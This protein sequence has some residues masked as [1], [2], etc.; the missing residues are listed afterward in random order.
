MRVDELI[1]VTILEGN[2]KKYLQE[3]MMKDEIFSRIVH[4]KVFEKSSRGRK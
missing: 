1:F 4:G 3:K 2:K